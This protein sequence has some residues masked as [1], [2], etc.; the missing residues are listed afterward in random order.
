[1]RLYIL[2]SNSA[3]D[4]IAFHLFGVFKRS[5]SNSYVQ[6]NQFTL[7]PELAGSVSTFETSYIITETLPTSPALPPPPITAVIHQQQP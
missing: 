2:S 1:M 5:V 7:S 4:D 6:C 3:E